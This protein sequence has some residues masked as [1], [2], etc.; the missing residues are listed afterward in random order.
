M[1][2]FQISTS[3][4]SLN[5]MSRHVSARLTPSVGS[6]HPATYC[7]GFTFVELLV[8]LAVLII[9]AT[10]IMGGHMGLIRASSKVRAL[11]E[12]RLVESTIASEAWMATAGVETIGSDI[13][14][15]NVAFEAVVV[16][17]G[18]N[19]VAWNRWTISPSNDPKL[20]RVL[21]LQTAPAK[22]NSESAGRP[23]F[24]GGTG[25][26]PPPGLAPRQD[27]WRLNR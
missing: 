8:A 18:T 6:Q 13:E 26:T 20:E 4:L 19:R 7:S 12:S 14:G 27:S 2:T 25:I 11:E 15:W 21:Y 10:V 24:G 16:E 23:I 3:S 5:E 17:D 1:P 9:L 22:T